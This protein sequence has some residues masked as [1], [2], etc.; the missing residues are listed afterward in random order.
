[1]NDA[2][3]GEQ[4]DRFS[5]AE[6]H[7]DVVVRDEEHLLNLVQLLEAHD[8]DLARAGG[9]LENKAELF[10]LTLANYNHIRSHGHALDRADL[11]V[12]L[13]VCLFIGGILVAG[14][15][16]TIIFVIHV[17][18]LGALLAKVIPRYAHLHR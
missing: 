8:A 3:I 6:V 4:G 5:T 2:A 14:I 1:M 17:D 16:V 15:L 7:E 10:L 9:R 13:L 12:I 18:S 11:P